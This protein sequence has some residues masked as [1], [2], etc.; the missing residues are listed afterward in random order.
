MS[1][2]QI[3]A[4]SDEFRELLYRMPFQVPEDLILLGR[5]IGILSGMASGL[6][7]DFSV[8]KG[9][10]LYVRRLMRESGEGRTRLLL[11]EL[12]TGFKLV[13]GLPKRADDLAARML[14][15]KLEVRTPELRQR[16]EALESGMRKI[17]GSIVFA[18]GLIAG[19]QLYLNGRL[20]AVLILGAAEF[21]LLL[22][23]LL[24]S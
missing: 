12:E 19:T 2:R 17:A 8:W 24:A 9:L 20:E 3:K 21:L 23:L 1:E 7:P 5:D 15:G 10:S 22:W 18:A 11:K 16:I 4:F 13:L 14:E 6:D